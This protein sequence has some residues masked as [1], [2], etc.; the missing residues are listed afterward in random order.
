MDDGDRNVIEQAT[1]PVQE[2]RHGEQPGEV[3]HFVQ[4]CPISHDGE[5][6]VA[7][8]QGISRATCGHWV[9]RHHQAPD[10]RCIA[11][12]VPGGAARA[13]GV[14]PTPQACST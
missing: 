4:A 9:T 14:A 8:V 2:R 11:C 6:L 13:E 7:V 12:A 5:D 1:Q 3:H 10:G